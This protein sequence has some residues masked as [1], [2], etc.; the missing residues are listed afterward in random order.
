MTK[1]DVVKRYVQERIQKGTW[2]AGDKIP[3]EEELVEILGVSRN[4][5][6]H[7]LSELVREGWIYKLRGSGSYVRKSMDTKSVDI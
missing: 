6:R 1:Y 2:K 7:G 4:P 3:S 5:V